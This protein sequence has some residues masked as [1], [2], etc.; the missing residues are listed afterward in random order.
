MVILFDYL[1]NIG[2]LSAK[3]KWEHKKSQN[4]FWD[5]YQGN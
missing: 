2:N 1:A 4:F 5:F 3:K